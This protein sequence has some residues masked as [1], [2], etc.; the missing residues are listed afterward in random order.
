MLT[1]IKPRP[2]TRGSIRVFD[3]VQVDNAG[4]KT[5]TT[6]L[7]HTAAEISRTLGLAA[8]GKKVYA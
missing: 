7:A 4:H 1:I 2:E 5:R 8:A 3:V 6:Q